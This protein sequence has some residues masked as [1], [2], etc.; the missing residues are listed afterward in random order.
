MKIREKPGDCFLSPNRKFAACLG[1]ALLILASVFS[2][3][4]DA[5]TGFYTQIAVGDPD[6]VGGTNA[7][8][9]LGTGL[10]ESQLGPNG[11]PVLS[12][13]GIAR[14]GTALDMNSAT[15][16][17]LWWSAGADPFVSLDS[18]PVQTNSMPFTYGYPNVNWYPTG[19]T[20]DNNSYRAVHWRGTFNMADSDS[21]SL[22]LAVDDDAWVFIDGTLVT[23]NH[24]GYV[25][26]ISVPV[27]SGT[28]SIEMFY[29]DRFPIYDAVQF[30]SS[31]P[32]S[33][34]APVM[35]NFAATPISGVAPLT[36]SFTD[37]SSGPV[38]AWNWSFGDGETSPAQN[39]THTYIEAGNYT[40]SLTVTG[41]PGE[42][43]SIRQAVTATK[44]PPR[45]QI[46]SLIGMVKGLVRRGKLSRDDGNQLIAGLDLTL[47]SLDRGGW[48]NSSCEQTAEF[49]GRVH[50][51]VNR[52]RLT[53]TEG[54]ALIDVANE[55]RSALGC[56]FLQGS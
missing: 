14:L 54:Q 26:D 33:V 32:L 41:G 31:V 38:S 55:L 49:I 20:G 17:L 51:F 24:Y 36:V 25:S 37:S 23:E 43:D 50:A 19:Q 22:H 46:G 30:S 8:G 40:V 10:V 18:N 15:H 21:I 7:G 5:L 6:F 2:A 29:D 52:R 27:S 44:L 12:T 3:R 42:A 4:S 48:A 56:P 53:S 1:M 34:I 16:E 11:L 9:I 47:H 45:Q 13:A 39:P 28:H 35:A